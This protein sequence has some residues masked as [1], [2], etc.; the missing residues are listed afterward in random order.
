MKKILLAFSMLA[1]LASC[2]PDNPKIYGTWEVVSWEV[3]G[4]DSGRSVEAITFQ[5]NEDDTY[6]ISGGTQKEEGIY[7]LR[8][9]K[10]YSTENGDKLEKVVQ[11]SMPN[12]ETLVFLMNRV[13][14]DERLIL[15]KK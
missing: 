14:D 5:F 6:S 15:E 13:G 8:G 7:S 12:P 2:A 4:K 9:D 10:L 1:F 11:V 3:N